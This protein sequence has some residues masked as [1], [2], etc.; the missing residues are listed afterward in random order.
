M[1]MLQSGNVGLWNETLLFFFDF[2][3]SKVEEDP[4]YV[5][6]LFSFYSSAPEDDTNNFEKKDFK[7]IMP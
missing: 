6:L 2:L 1:A 4:R 5:D 7:V 3:L